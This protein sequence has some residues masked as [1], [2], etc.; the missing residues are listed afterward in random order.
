MLV[1]PA[2]GKGKDISIGACDASP[3]VRE[4]AMVSCKCGCVLCLVMQ[5]SLISPHQTHGRTP[6]SSAFQPKPL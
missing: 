4:E 6:R 5:V 3:F 1:F 2:L